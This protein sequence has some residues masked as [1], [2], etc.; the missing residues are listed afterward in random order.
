MKF[1]FK[2]YFKLRLLQGLRCMHIVTTLY[3]SVLVYIVYTVRIKCEQQTDVAIT[4]MVKFIEHF[5]TSNV[6]SFTRKTALDK[7][8]LKS[9]IK[10]EYN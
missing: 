5:I 8:Y 6:S 7:I 1:K 3:Y 4:H 2:S 9:D 10:D